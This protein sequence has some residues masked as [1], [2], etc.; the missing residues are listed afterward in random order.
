M[1]ELNE[2]NYKIKGSND[3][4]ECVEGLEAIAHWMRDSSFDYE[5]K[6]LK[7]LFQDVLKTYNNYLYEKTN[8]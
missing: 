7:Y 8:I 1:S 6:D 2:E 3:L 4:W 5:P